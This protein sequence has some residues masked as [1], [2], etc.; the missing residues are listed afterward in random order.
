MS[1]LATVDDE[2]PRDRLSG[3]SLKRNRC[4]IHFTS[5][6]IDSLQLC[7]NAPLTFSSLQRPATNGP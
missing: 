7:N 1:L 4:A 3:N 5:F 2:R 6:L